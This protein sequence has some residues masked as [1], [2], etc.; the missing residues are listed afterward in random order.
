MKAYAGTQPGSAPM[1]GYLG[2]VLLTAGDATGARTAFLASKNADPNFQPADVGLALLDSKEGNLDSARQTLRRLI[3][4]K[5]S[6]SLAAVR[7]AMI[8]ESAHNYLAAIAAF[9]TA[10]ETRTNDWVSLNDLAYCL[11]LTG[12][13]DDAL[14]Y[15]QQAKEIAPDDP[16]VSDTLGWAFYNKG[17]YDAAV[18]QLEPLKNDPAAAH[19]YHLAMAYFKRGDVV[20]G[21]KRFLM[22]L[23]RL[24]PVVRRQRWLN[25]LP[26]MET[27]P[28]Q[29]IRKGSCCRLL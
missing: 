9:K 11:I 3:D 22:L 26:Q 1:Q 20:R 13:A 6:N 15:A 23:T 18:R 21:R 14:K 7:L 24:S 12:H 25:W 5:R 10:L 27:R 19:R 8:E 17:M 4:G 29:T 16:S 28:S 2:E